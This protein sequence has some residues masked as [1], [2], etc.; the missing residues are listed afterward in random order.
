MLQDTIRAIR[1]IRSEQNIKP[2]IL[3]PSRLSAGERTEI[4]RQQKKL[5][6]SLAQID[7]NLFEI[8]VS[9]PPKQENQVSIAIGPVEV[10]IPLE[11]LVDTSEERDRLNKALIDVKSQVDRLEKLLASSFAERPRSYC[12]ERER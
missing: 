6:A 12:P 2:G 4:F 11:G 3:I 5:V 10:Y 9:L 7:P 8:A 1:N